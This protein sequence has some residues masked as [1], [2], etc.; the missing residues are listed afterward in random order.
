MDNKKIAKELVRLAKELEAENK[1]AGYDD[2]YY[3]KLLKKDREFARGLQ[4]I[5]KAFQRW[6]KSGVNDNEIPEARMQTLEYLRYKL[7]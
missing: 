6:K 7:K 3:L 2:E 5:E 4:M 1:Q